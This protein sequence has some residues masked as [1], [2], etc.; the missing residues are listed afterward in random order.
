M[1]VFSIHKTDYLRIFK[2]P[3]C[4]ELFRNNPFMVGMLCCVMHSPGS[5][6]HYSDIKVTNGQLTS[7]KELFNIDE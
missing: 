6:C 5:C 7:I 2:C 1:V 4:G 3:V